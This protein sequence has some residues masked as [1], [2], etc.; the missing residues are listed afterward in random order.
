MY[1]SIILAYRVFLDLL[2]KED[3][4]DLEGIKET[5]GTLVHQDL[6]AFRG[7]KVSNKFK[8]DINAGRNEPDQPFQNGWEFL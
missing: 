7:Q 4:L 2:V 3:L 1:L 6:K 5:E 8:L